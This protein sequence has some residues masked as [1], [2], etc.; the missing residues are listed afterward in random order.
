MTVLFIPTLND[1]ILRDTG[2]SRAWI[3]GKTL[4]EILEFLQIIEKKI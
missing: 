1:A 2:E 3:P 4:L